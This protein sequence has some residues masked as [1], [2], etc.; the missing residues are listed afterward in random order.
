[1]MGLGLA[2]AVLGWGDVERGGGGVVWGMEAEVWVWWLI[3]YLHTWFASVREFLLFA[4]V[5]K[6]LSFAWNLIPP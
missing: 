3:L 2:V 5:S 4:V 1:M 6:L